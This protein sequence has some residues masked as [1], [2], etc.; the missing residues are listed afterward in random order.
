M[1]LNEE[2][3]AA[4]K[5]SRTVVGYRE[6]M[7]ILKTGKVELVVVSNNMPPNMK[8]D[9]EHNAKMSDVRMEIFVGSSKDLGIVC[10]KP[11]SVTVL[12]IK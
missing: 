7:K 8:N 5:A 4:T 11:F 6:V 1:V 12:A 3:Q 2:I 9:I 10:G